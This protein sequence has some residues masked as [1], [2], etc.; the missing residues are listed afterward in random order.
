[1]K[2]VKT[3]QRYLHRASLHDVRHDDDDDDPTAHV[4][5]CYWRHSYVNRS[6]RRPVRSIYLYSIFTSGDRPRTSD[7][8]TVYTVLQVYSFHYAVKWL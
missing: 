1:M 5:L 6:K 3:R 2:R 4:G 7:L 8:A